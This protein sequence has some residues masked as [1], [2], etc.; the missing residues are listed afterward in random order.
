[1]YSLRGS[2]LLDNRKEGI[3]VL[4]GGLTIHNLSDLSSMSSRMA[5]PLHKSFDQAILDAVSV[6]DVRPA[7][8]ALLRDS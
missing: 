6:P 2:R 7:L 4:S 8:F 3:L 5:S 1:M